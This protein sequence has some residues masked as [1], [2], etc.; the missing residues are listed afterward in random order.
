MT[1]VVLE[2]ER[3]KLLHLERTNE[4]NRRDY[5]RKMRVRLREGSYAE[6]RAVDMAE[7]G[8]GIEAIMRGTGIDMKTATALVLGENP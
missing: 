2:L 1:S 8:Y 6:R 7:A 3:A 5:R 4:R